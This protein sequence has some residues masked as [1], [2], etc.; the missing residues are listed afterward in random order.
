MGTL[1]S[2]GTATS[3]VSVGWVMQENYG[4]SI[5]TGVLI[6]CILRTHIHQETPSMTIARSRRV[7][8]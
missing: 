7:D 2:N 4:I 5:L 8:G 1:R 6:L 3:S